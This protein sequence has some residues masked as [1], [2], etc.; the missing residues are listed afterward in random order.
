MDKIYTYIN[1]VDLLILSYFDR[2][3]CMNKS[4]PAYYMTSINECDNYKESLKKILPGLRKYNKRILVGLSNDDIEILNKWKNEI[5]K[6][7]HRL[8]INNQ[9]GGNKDINQ[10]NYSINDYITYIK[11]IKN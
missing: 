3:L 6:I 5:Y 7:G 4:K 11:S 10:I 1:V 8:I 2:I 9:Y